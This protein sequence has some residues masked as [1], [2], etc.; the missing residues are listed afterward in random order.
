MSEFMLL[1]AKAPATLEAVLEG[2]AHLSTLSEAEILERVSAGRARDLFPFKPM[3]DQEIPSDKVAEDE[4]VEASAMPLSRQQRSSL[5]Q[6][7]MPPSATARSA[8][9]GTAH[10]A[11]TSK[12]R[13]F[14]SRKPTAADR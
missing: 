10:A 6:S 12:L 5:I 1:D 14:I 8:R 3:S 4:L 13:R 2:V 11:K 9:K 7:S